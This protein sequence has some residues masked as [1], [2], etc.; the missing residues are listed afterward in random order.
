MN[1]RV[2]LILVVCLIT[3]GCGITDPY[4][5]TTPHTPQ[6][7]SSAATTTKTTTT[8]ADAADPAPERGGTVPATAQATQH[9]L[10]ADASAATAP[11]ALAR[12]GR[13]D[14]NWQAAT[15]AAQ[16]R[17]LAALSV[18]QARAAALQAAASAARDPELTHSH[19]ENHGQLLAITPGTGPA[20][21]R[22]VIVTTETTTGTG[23]YAGLP[24]A[25]HV[26][27][28]QVTHTPSG[29]VVSQWSPET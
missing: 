3:T 19:V 23:D 24:A 7:A 20:S 11:A 2:L 15:L 5:G 8:A 13:L 1:A 12:Y 25:L 21:G 18:D 10:A 14:I 16:Q 9:A 28:A 26:T 17:R 29:W 4:R 27:Y 22:W 6:T